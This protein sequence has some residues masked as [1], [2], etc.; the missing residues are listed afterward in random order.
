MS[1]CWTSVVIT[2]AS[3]GIGRALAEALAA[4]E[5]RLLLLG[6][7]MERLE[8]VTALCRAQGAVAEP[9][10][11]DVVDGSALATVLAAFEA[12]AP[13]DLVIANAGISAGLGPDRSPEPPGIA[14]KIMRANVEGVLNTVEPLLPGMLARGEGQIALMS[15]IAA[16]RPQPDLPSYSASKA[17]VRAYGIALR[18]WLRP[19]GIAVSVICPGFVTSPMSARHRGAKPWEMPAEPAAAL[20]LRGLARRRAF[21]SFPWP[22]VLLSWLDN[23]FLPAWLSDRM[24]AMFAA[25]VEPEAPPDRGPRET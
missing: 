13:V 25:T 17:A 11:A 18:G 24:V 3:S 5:R 7:D 4:P 20:I 6:R 21:I 14:R 16:L 22:L 12:K 9:V 8:A 10:V 23:R 1:G 15:S 2:G 19:R